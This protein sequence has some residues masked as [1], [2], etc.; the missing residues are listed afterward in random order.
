MK[1]FLKKQSLLFCGVGTGLIARICDSSGVDLIGIYNSGRL[2]MNGI[3]AIAG[4][5]P[6]TDAKWGCFG[7][8]GEGYPSPGEEHPGHSRDIWG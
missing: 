6:V 5:L 8:G 4:N 7:N 2:R 1:K 3:A